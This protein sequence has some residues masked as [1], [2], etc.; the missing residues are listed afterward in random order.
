MMNAP[1]P[2]GL[3]VPDETALSNKERLPADDAEVAARIGEEFG[4]GAVE[5][6]SRIMEGT[7]ASDAGCAFVAFSVAIGLP[8]AL[9]F[10]ISSAPAWAKVI[11]AAGVAGLL[12]LGVSLIAVGRRRE[13]VV[14]SRLALY[15]GGVAQIDRDE[16]EPRVLRWA[17]VESLTVDLQTDEGTLI[18]RL[19]S[20][21][22]RGRTG[23]EISGGA[24]VETVVRAAHRALAPRLVPPLIE[25]FDSGQEV[26]AGAARIDSAGLTLP[27][28]KR[29]AWAQIKSVIM[30]HPS[31]ASSEVA[32]R[33]DVR[34]VSRFRLHIF[35]PS[36][37][38]NAIFL[39]HVLARAAAR[40]G[41]AVDGYDGAGD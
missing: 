34:A 38:P 10:A 32:T 9:G 30:Y 20:F 33:I 15:S 36:K 2:D 4:L 24:E 26:A 3:A 14:R 28:G 11:F 31:P 12:F 23:T 19:A 1:V 39:A 18:S 29:L 41:V 35:N 8:I 7:G 13:V 40:N 6:V 17:D 21:T 25:T 37:I 22:L 5:S 27:S 16:P